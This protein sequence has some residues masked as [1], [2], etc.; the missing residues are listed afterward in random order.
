MKL[1]ITELKIMPCKNVRRLANVIVTFDDAFTI[2]AK[3]LEGPK[4][5]KTYFPPCCGFTSPEAQKEIDNRI[6][7][8]YVINRCVDEY[9][10]IL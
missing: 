1:E 6:L 8:T 4:G 9:N 10:G 7:A 5:I 3:I 2:T